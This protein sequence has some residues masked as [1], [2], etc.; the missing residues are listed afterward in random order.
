MSLETYATVRGTA[1]KLKEMVR[2]ASGG[3]HDDVYLRVL[4]DEDTVQFVT[5]S[6]GQQVMSYCTFSDLKHVEGDAEAIIPTGLDND[7]K[8]YLDYL[9]IA[10]GSGTVEM[11]LLGEEGGSG[12]DHPYL[13]SHW[14]AEGALETTIRLPAS[15]DDLNKVP[16]MLPERWTESNGYL[17]SSAFE[18]GELAVDDPSDYTPPTV[19]ETTSSTVR[20]SIVQPAEFVDGVEYRPIIVQDGEFRL[21]LQG[22]DGDD[23]I[24]GEVNA[25]QVK[26]PDVDRKF[27]EG[28]DAVF[29]ELSGPVR[30][31][32]APTSPDSNVAPPLV[33][34]Q[35]EL[36]GRAIRHVLGPFQEV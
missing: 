34:V 15:A 23:S 28:F 18:D 31:S 9:S 2:L 16:W 26:G 1:Q 29:S 36:S 35:D 11:Q 10:E 25:E 21:D 22:H 24:A 3:Y 14:K 13:A 20:D 4:G 19:V 30:I 33:I 32:T 27:D 8:G 7:T 12:G 17:S 6:G 5:Q